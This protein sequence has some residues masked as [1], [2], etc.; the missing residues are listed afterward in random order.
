MEERLKTILELQNQGYSKKEISE[1]MGYSRPS[2]LS[3]WMKRRGYMYNETDQRYIKEE[4]E[5]E[6]KE[7][8]KKSLELIDPKKFLFIDDNELK[9]K[10]LRMAEQYDN[11]QDMLE[12]FRT[13][14]RQV[15]SSQK[16]EVIEVIN[17]GIQINL[18]KVDSIKTSIRVNNEV[19]REFGIFAENHSEFVK[20]D[21]LC[22][23]LREFMDKHK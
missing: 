2:N 10:I 21:L 9:K 8:E 23:A 3:S 7:R 13:K 22:Q 17:Q 15:S 16:T 19:W 18:P 6:V 20:G 11:I 5:Q 1:K 12:W 14:D 4:I